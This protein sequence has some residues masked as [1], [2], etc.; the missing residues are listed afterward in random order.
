MYRKDSLVFLGTS[1]GTSWRELAAE[2]CGEEGTISRLRQR[3]VLRSVLLEK[4]LTLGTIAD[5]GFHLHMVLLLA[6]W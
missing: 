2:T 5:N 4:Y 6:Y 3:R 1:L